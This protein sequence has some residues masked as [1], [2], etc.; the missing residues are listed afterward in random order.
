[1]SLILAAASST[2]WL[3]LYLSI[4]PSTCLCIFT[5][6]ILVLKKREGKNNAYS[7]YLYETDDTELPGYNI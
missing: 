2:I 4:C 7:A 3:R 1:M 6:Y 5:L